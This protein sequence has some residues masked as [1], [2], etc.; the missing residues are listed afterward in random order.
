MIPASEIREARRRAGLTQAKLAARAGT[1][2]A[3]LSA[4]ERGS[5]TPSVGTYARLLAACGSRLTVETGHPP[6]TIPSAALHQRTARRLAQVLALAAELP[7]R[8]HR[9]LH[10]PRL[11]A[12]R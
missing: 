4:Y 7:T 9:E 5:K 1:S 8:H 6:L 11:G 12:P 3:T 2:Q 10:F